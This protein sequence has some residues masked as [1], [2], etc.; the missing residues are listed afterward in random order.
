MKLNEGL[1][2]TG[3]H[4]F[5][6]AGHDKIEEGALRGCVSLKHIKVPSTVEMIGSYAFRDCKQMIGGSFVVG[7]R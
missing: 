5:Y 3:P 4:R 1:E 2:Q 7:S 6:L